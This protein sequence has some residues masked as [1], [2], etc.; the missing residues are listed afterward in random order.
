M[1]L[2]GEPRL[3]WRCASSHYQTC[4]FEH[5]DADAALER[6]RFSHVARARDD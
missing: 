5:P 3:Y 6:G 2:G 4:R 1:C